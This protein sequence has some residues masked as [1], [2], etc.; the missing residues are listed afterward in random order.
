VGD[1]IRDL[2]LVVFMVAVAFFIAMAGVAVFASV[3]ARQRAAIVRAMPT[4]PIGMA[5][6][7]Y[8]EL[9]GRIEAVGGDAVR[10][11]LTQWPVVWYHARVEQLKDAPGGHDSSQWRTV[12]DV[13][14]AAPFL[15][16]DRT[17]VAIVLPLGAEVTP[18]DKSR[19][20]GDS[21]VPADRNPAKVKPT[22]SATPMLDIAGT[23]KFRYYEERM[24]AGDPLLVLGEF[25][26][27]RFGPRDETDDQEDAAAAGELDP[28][29]KLLVRAREVTKATIQRGTGKQ[30]FM[31]TTT[32]QAEHLKLTSLGSSA[33]LGVAVVPLLLAALLLWVRFG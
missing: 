26:S 25:T 9:E 29:D 8:R 27:G 19:W 6:D 13:T 20:Y 14:S 32:S 24:Y 10:A 28:D 22:E 30:P 2:P 4:S 18:T 7:G 15:V 12:S 33:A 21:K 17:G 1:I 16:R 23:A 31:M 5:A 11:P 3:H